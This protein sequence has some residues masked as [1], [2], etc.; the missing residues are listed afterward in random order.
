MLKNIVVNQYG[1]ITLKILREKPIKFIRI[2]AHL[3]I[4]IMYPWGTNF[5]KN[6][7][8]IHFKR[9]FENKVQFQPFKSSQP[10]FGYDFRK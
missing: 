10:P 9:T 6:K 7:K 1:E 4:P 5:L 2:K 3:S 8:K